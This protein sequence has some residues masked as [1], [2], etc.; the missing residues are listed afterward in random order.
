VS[1]DTPDPVFDAETFPEQLYLMAFGDVREAVLKGDFESG[2][3]HY[4]AFGKLEIASGTRHSPFKGG[5][6]GLS[7]S[8]LPTAPETDPVPPAPP[9]QSL[10][11]ALGAIAYT[12]PKP[13]RAKPASAPFSASLYLATNP[14]VPALIAAGKAQSAES[15]WQSE[16][17]SQT[18]A[19]LRPTLTHD[20]LYAD[21]APPPPEPDLAKFDGESYLLLYPDVLKAL[22][23]DPVS[24]RAHYLHHGRFEARIA[25]GLAPYATM[26][27][28]PDVLL[29]KPFGLNIYA[30]FATVSGLGTAARNILRAIETT[31]I[32]FDLHAFDVSRGKARITPSAHARKPRYRCN[33]I[34]A[35]ADQ[36]A[37]LISIYQPGTFDNAYNIAVWAWELAA[38]RPDWQLSFAPLDE[39]WTNSAFECASISATSPL[40][41]HKIRLPVEPDLAGAREG[42]ALFGIPHDRLTFMVAFDAGS[43][44][45][46]KNPL[47]AVEAF[48]EAFSDQD[49]V[50]LI[51]KFHQTSLEP[52]ITRQISRA[53]RGAD[54][55]LVI[56]DVLSDRDMSL[57]RDACDVFVSPHRSEGFGL[58]LAEFM[59]LGKPVIATNYSG[60]LEFFDASVGYPV[61]YDLT[62][63][64][65][66][67]AS[68]MPHYIWAEP[69]RASVVAA[70]R[71]I[72][73]N[74]S[75]AWAKGRRAAKR[76]KDG[77]SYAAV[78]AGIVARL[79]TLG[80]NNE[81]P[82]CFAWFGKTRGMTGAAPL[83]L[84]QPAQRQAV[85]TLGADRPVISLIVPIYN[86]PA[87]LLQE[88]VF[89]VFAQSYPLWE[90]CLYNDASTDPG[91][92]E[93]LQRLQGIDPRIRIRHGT[94]NL[95]IAGAS[96][97]AAEMSTGAWLAMLDN[98]DALHP[99]A[100]LEIARALVADPSIDVLYTDE[101]KI[102]AQ[103]RKIDTYF[104]PDWSPEHLESVMYVLHL[105]V[106]RKKL[107]LELSGFR[108]AYSGAQDYDLML[109]LSRRTQ[110]I[111]HIAKPLYHWRAVPGSAAAQVDA[112]PY[113]LEAGLR[114]LSDHVAARHGERASVEN[115]LLPGT[116]R[117]RRQILGQ[118]RVSLLI[119]TNNVE[120]DLPGRGR[121]HMVDNLVDS[122]LRRTAYRNYE[123][124]VVDNNSLKSA[125]LDR[126][127]ALGVR[128]ENYPGSVKPFN[129]SAKANYALRVCRT[130]H[131]VYLND[132][133][134]VADPDWLT[135]L[136]EISQDPE[137]GAVGA[138]LLHAD[139]TVQHVGCVIG[140]NGGS[141]HVYH[142]YPGEFVGYNGFTHLI[143]NYSAVT[144]A[145]FATRKS[146]LAQLG[147]FD[148]AYALDFNDIDLCLRLIEAG[149][150]IVYTPYCTLF[151]FEG[152]SAKR[153]SANPEERK[154]FIAAWPRYMENDPYFNPNF[155][156]R[157][158]DFTLA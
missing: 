19:G 79:E 48:R 135:A 60:N 124:V 30:P 4:K 32:P 136:L 16:G 132:D 126:F 158:F 35:N 141:V 22:G 1:T 26:Q 74:Q 12:S 112:K 151:H 118:P 44:S 137:I 27:A 58:N 75:G 46:R 138:R 107:F 34:L 77:F 7:R 61:D 55:V 153:V 64:A 69:R 139:G 45:A 62:E 104:K 24:A 9:P 154:R 91:T 115:G 37:Q 13:A 129:Y 85:M 147:G 67:S 130:E 155:S 142:S 53:L 113:A 40:P 148:E 65:T 100:M 89:S 41:V 92:L 11:G 145:C 95:G 125:Q 134:E 114:A 97:A 15:H 59:A 82:A 110:R 101:D 78:G 52:G 25:C 42:R 150:R 6:P 84:L 18:E 105:L 63:I 133:M 57:L 80:L 120:L 88:C 50:F 38:F 76:L 102:D 17:R 116:F 28:R 10:A 49:N 103:G 108:S 143:R 121:F 96:N 33:L 156:K 43:T 72:H 93:V 122:I 131:L 56:A 117:V 31:G 51:V 70:L 99:D 152:A 23:P 119:L 21:P 36:I 140:V 71:A 68:Y 29:Q 87:H 128:V 83:R 2:Y 106:V 14:D 144:G 54:N 127:R 8:I 81:K 3:A 111:H 73:E 86:V 157:H 146:V 5:P 109:R 20:S 39:I 123:V 94:K 90:L 149:Y 66:Q 98:D 47:L